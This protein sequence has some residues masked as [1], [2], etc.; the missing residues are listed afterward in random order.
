VTVE[1]PQSRAD[2]VS[3]LIRADIVGGTYPPGS[4]LPS[5]KNLAA[6]YGVAEKTI[7]DAVRPLRLEGL[8]NA[9]QGGGGGTFVRPVGI[10]RSVRVAR[11]L[12][13]ER[14]EGGS[15]GAFDGEIRRQGMEPRVDVTVTPDPVAPPDD[16]AAILRTDSTIRRQRRMY[17]ND[18]P[19]QMA[20]TWL[21]ADIAAGTQI[22]QE[23]TGPGGMMSRLAELGH[24]VVRITE[25]VLTRTPASG[26][27][28][29][30]GLSPGQAVTEIRRVAQ[31]A[32]RR[33]VEVTQ[34]VTPATLWELTYEW[35]LT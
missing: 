22:A 18:Y 8:L 31:T 14:E 26:E 34:M 24:A 15:R 23:D 16:V 28:A 35:D 25:T 20:T 33:T 11:Q 4:R 6:Q 10:I 13:N 5:A 1:D 19:V 29:F 17:A 7:Y 32:D 27:S 12:P 9:R 3:A 2:Q 21:P 30:L